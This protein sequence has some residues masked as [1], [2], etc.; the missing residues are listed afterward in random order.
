MLHLEIKKAK[1]MD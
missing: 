1:M